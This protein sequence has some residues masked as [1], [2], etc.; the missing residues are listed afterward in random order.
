MIWEACRLIF[1]TVRDEMRR[2]IVLV[3]MIMLI[4]LAHPRVSCADTMVFDF[5]NDFRSYAQMVALINKEQSSL[6]TSKGEITSS[7]ITYSALLGK[8][9]GREVDFSKV[10]PLYVIWGPKYCFTLFFSSEK[11]L[12]GAVDVMRKTEGIIYAEADC[13]VHANSKEGDE[14]A[15]EKITYSFH[16]WGAAQ[17]NLGYYID[18]AESWGSGSASVA[19]IDSGV[20]PH[21]LIRGKLLSGGYD[22]VDGDDDSLND[23]FGHGTN[24]AGII[25][26]CTQDAPV[27]ICPIRVLNSS[28]NG[29][30]SNVVNAVREAKSRG[31][32]I[33]NLSLESTV[34]SEA[35]DDAILE[36]VSSGITVVVA[37]GNSSCNTSEVCPAHLTNSGVIVVGAAEGSDGSYTRA[38][39]S[40]YGASIDVYAFGTS[41]NCCS[42]SGGYSDETG[43][44]MAAPHVSALCALMHLIHPDESPDQAENRLKRAA[45]GS[46]AVIVPDSM[47]MIPNSK[48]FFLDAIRLC[49]GDSLPLP[50]SAYPMS[51]GETIS[52]SSS[53]EQI[54]RYENGALSAIGQGSAYVTVSCKGFEDQTIPV[55]VVECAGSSFLL[56]GSII[57]IEDEALLGIT[58][59]TEMSIPDTVVEI[60]NHILEECFS[61]NYVFIPSSVERIGENTFSNAIIICQI[62]SAIYQYA[63]DH[64]LQYTTVD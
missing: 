6:L 46:N 1:K 48:G 11:A 41:I 60:G 37:A 18:Y 2:D 9:D 17:M 24:V 58:A 38:S 63:V 56:P 61:L 14:S 5:S 8:T 47:L 52:Y 10:S 13:E 27:Y 53:D 7:A 21:P 19:V 50:A 32:T 3:F 49:S 34:M 62:G 22:Y 29:K 12:L 28:G 36:A 51:A 54:I 30:M 26:D 16:S 42:R 35:L 33:I 40:N 20:F 64:E 45:S 25:A 44:S 43:T 59:L 57:V 55:S 39:Y 31:V 23:L 4:M 15:E